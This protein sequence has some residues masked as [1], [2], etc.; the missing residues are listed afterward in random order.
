MG[1]VAKQSVR[2]T[3]P[4]S[5]A[6]PGA[7]YYQI[8]R[9]GA[10]VAENDSPIAAWP[11]GHGKRGCGRGGCGRG[12]WGKSAGGLGCGLGGCGLGGWGT[13][14]ACL[15]MDTDLITDGVHVWA[16]VAYDGAGNAS[17][18][19][20]TAA[21]ALAGVPESPSAVEADEYEDGVLSVAFALSPDDEG[22]A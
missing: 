13:G 9:D 2:L 12:R 11:D 6:V 17:A 15:T 7:G 8:Y 5:Q 16:I 14:G 20:P 10:A 1:I 3:W 18:G 19:N 22:S 21:L 4:Q